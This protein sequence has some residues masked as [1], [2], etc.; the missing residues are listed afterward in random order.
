MFAAAGRNVLHASVNF[1]TPS[2]CAVFYS[3]RSFPF[4]PEGIVAVP[5]LRPSLSLHPYLPTFR[6]AL[7]RS[8]RE[9]ALSLS[10]R[11][12]RDSPDGC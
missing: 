9:L 1:I 12:N 7:N 5:S 6:I 2:V 10:V 11:R 4:K 8:I 3:H